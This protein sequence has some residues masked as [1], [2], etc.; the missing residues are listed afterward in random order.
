MA[1]SAGGND[2]MK[3]HY[4]EADLLETWY[5]SLGQSLP[6]ME[7]LTHCRVCVE[8]YERLERKLREAAACPAERPESFWAAQ[9]ESI[10]GRVAAGGRWRRA[11]P[12]RVA[13]AALLVVVLGGLGIYRTSDPA[14]PAV[15]LT[16]TRQVDAA[17]QSEALE[18]PSD[19]WESEALR[20]YQPVVEWE[21]WVSESK[22]N[23]GAQTL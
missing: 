21:S 12:L 10:T 16:A 2:I 22:T 3:E 14:P 5:V 19:P 20:D 23:E 13:A 4:S 7:H 15:A 18:V 9:R 6:V 11:A 17:A 1:S 8:R